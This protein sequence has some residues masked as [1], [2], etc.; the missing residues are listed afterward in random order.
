MPLKTLGYSIIKLDR[1]EGPVVQQQWVSPDWSSSERYTDHKF[2]IKVFTA[3][4]TGIL[5]RSM[6]F[7]SIRCYFFSIKKDVELIL[8]TN[9]S[10]RTSDMDRVWS[11]CNKMFSDHKDNYLRLDEKI[12]SWAAGQR[13]KYKS[14][15]KKQILESFC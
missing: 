8:F 15:I 4:K 9:R 1:I 7:D 3:I 6:D 5:P 12:R 14:A 11:R 13:T 2:N 10:G